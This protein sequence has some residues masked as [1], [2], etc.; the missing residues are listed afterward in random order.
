MC[1]PKTQG[2]IDMSGSK[3]VKDF[4][5]LQYSHA[6]GPAGLQTRKQNSLS[7]IC[8]RVKHEPEDLN[9]TYE[10][11]PLVNLLHIAKGI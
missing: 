10:R 1:W 5:D 3:R 2:K 8:T 11:G 7:D 4:I 9:G 6:L